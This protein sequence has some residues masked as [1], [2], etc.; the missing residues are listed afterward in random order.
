MIGDK[1]SE[2]ETMWSTH[3]SSEMRAA[4]MMEKLPIAMNFRQQCKCDKLQDREGF[5]PDAPLKDDSKVT[6]SIEILGKR[7]TQSK[8]IVVDLQPIHTTTVFD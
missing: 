7:E 6:K 2:A 1:E 8:T 5:P 4:N 3:P